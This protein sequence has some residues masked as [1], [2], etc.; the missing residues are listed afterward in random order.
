M[1]AVSR[2]SF[3]EKLSLGAGAVVLSPMVRSLVAEAQ[4][5]PAARKRFIVVSFSNGAF[6]RNWIPREH[7]PNPRD[8][9]TLE[10]SALSTRDHTLPEILEPLAPLR[11]KMLLLDGVLNREGEGAGHYS[12]N[13]LTAVPKIGTGHPDYRTI[14]GRSFDQHLAPVL[15]Q[16]APFTDVHIGSQTNEG[17]EAPRKLARHIFAK[18]PGQYI[19]V[20]LRPADAFGMLFPGNG[21]A[22]PSPEL[23]QR[24]RLLDHLADDIKRVRARLAPPERT[25]ADDYLGA[26]EQ[27][28]KRVIAFEQRAATCTSGSS[29]RLVDPLAVEADDVFEVQMD[30]ATAAVICGLTGVMS[31]SFTGMGRAWQKRF[32]FTAKIHDNG[33]SEA[34]LINGQLNPNER[35]RR[36]YMTF[37]SAQIARMAGRLD[38]VR[39]GDRTM[40]DNSVILYAADNNE[41]HHCQGHRVPLVLLGT[42]GGK[43]RADGRYHRLPA[44]RKFRAPPAAPAGGR[45]MGDVMSTLGH[46]LGAPID[47]WGKAGI[48]RVQGPIADLLA[49]PAKPPPSY[50]APE[51]S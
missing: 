29:L 40:L 35:L 46:A 39:E 10:E 3:L 47:D 9:T 31:V 14:G 36:Q 16:G 21:A 17:G 12:W 50:R 49:A 13:L 15:S 38:A 25:R 8:T 32:G 1:I 2:R 22:G 11:G 51:D 5:T 6:G 23:L 27:A 33:H 34:E 45:C 30:I 24:R 41:T 26:I 28:Q 4:G 43:L 48:E 7:A 42:A 44:L 20:V 19:D 37:F 18:G